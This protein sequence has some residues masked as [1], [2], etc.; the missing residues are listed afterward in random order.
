MAILR[1]KARTRLD[2]HHTREDSR[3]TVKV[4]HTSPEQI[5]SQ[6]YM[7]IPNKLMGIMNLLLY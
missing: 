3:A 1:V 7:F 6:K 5:T 4:N 2:F